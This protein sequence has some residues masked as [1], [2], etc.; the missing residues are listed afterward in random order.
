MKIFKFDLQLNKAFLV[1]KATCIGKMIILEEITSSSSSLFECLDY[2]IREIIEFMPLDIND[3]SNLKFFY[4][5]TNRGLFKIEYNDYFEV[6][7]KFI[8]QD[9]N[10]D[11]FEI[12]YG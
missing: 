3:Y 12:L 5:D 10:A 8:S 11:T 9:F 2:A 6:S 1:V 4:Y 7:C